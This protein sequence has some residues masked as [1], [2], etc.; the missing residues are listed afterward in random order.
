[1]QQG[2]TRDGKWTGKRTTS[3]PTM[4]IVKENIFYGEMG[5]K[6]K[7]DKAVNV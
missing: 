4:H 5:K 2:E 6:H 7:A 3:I 1:M